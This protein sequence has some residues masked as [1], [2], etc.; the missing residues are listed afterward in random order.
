MLILSQTARQVPRGHRGQSDLEYPKQ[1]E[2]FAKIVEV[3]AVGRTGGIQ[4]FRIRFQQ[5]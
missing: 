4:G 2:E 5:R 1:D 3:K